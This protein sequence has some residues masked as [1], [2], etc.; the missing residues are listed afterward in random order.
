MF[1]SPDLTVLLPMKKRNKH[2]KTTSAVNAVDSGDQKSVDQVRTVMY[3]LL[4]N[5]FLKHGLNISKYK[6]VIYDFDSLL[7]C[8]F[9]VPCCSG[10]RRGTSRGGFEGVA[11]RSISE[12]HFIHPWNY[13]IL[14]VK[15]RWEDLT[16]A[17]KK[18][19]R[20][21]RQNEIKRLK[22]TG[23]GN[24]PDDEVNH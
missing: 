8:G 3:C 13:F 6:S 16:T 9:M 2:G 5:L 7:F 18:K 22:F 19:E 14:K 23:N 17:V 11:T 24:L 21:A 20:S 15:K 10:E 4:I 1:S 12:Q